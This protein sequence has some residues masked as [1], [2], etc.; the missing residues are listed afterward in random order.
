MSDQPRVA[1]P[2]TPPMRPDLRAD[3]ANC[4]GLCCVVLRF[5]A[6]A[7]FA[8]GKPAGT[9]CRHLAEDR[10]CTIHAGLRERGMAGCDVYDCQGAGQKVTQVTFAQHD[11]R[12][13]PKTA[14][15]LVVVFP[16]VRQLHEI[17]A[18]LVE[19]ATVAAA[20][21][22][23]PQVEQLLADVERLTYLGPEELL[24]IDVPAQRAL[25]APVLSRVSELAR[26]PRPGPVQRDADLIG[27]DLRGQPLRRADLHGAYLIQADLRGVD[28]RGAD[29]FGA[30]LR[31]ADL[32]G[33]DLSGCLYLTQAQ[34][35]AARGDAGTRIP[36]HLTR[37][38]HW[39]LTDGRSR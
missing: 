23:R 26:G 13:D 34:L 8:F 30:D 35:Q 22:V 9:P 32:R 4:V 12:T 27:Q 19:A 24:R 21:E 10:R 15:W 1:P 11:W 3:C 7:D 31:D 33:A 29:L 39:R 5:D 2:P 20:A 25:V 18:Y 6:S 28:L 37:P 38:A 14:R 36:P 16:I 17:L